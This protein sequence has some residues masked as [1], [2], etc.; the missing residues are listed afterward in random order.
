MVE[1]EQFAT[2]LGRAL[3]GQLVI[4]RPNQKTAARSFFGGVRQGDGIGHAIASS[5]EGA[6]ALVRIRLLAVPPDHLVDPCADGE[7]PVTH[8]DG[9]KKARSDTFPPRQETR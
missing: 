3:L 9:P 7:T 8:R 5:H 4:R 2:E 6:A 1:A